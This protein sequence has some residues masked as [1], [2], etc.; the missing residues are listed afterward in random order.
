MVC[1][2]ARRP[3]KLQSV[4]RTLP[5]HKIQQ[6][7]HFPKARPSLLKP[8]V[9]L[10]MAFWPGTPKLVVL[11]QVWIWQGPSLMS[12]RKFKGRLRA[13]AHCTPSL[14]LQANGQIWILQAFLQ[15]IKSLCC[16][17][18]LSTQRK[19]TGGWKT[20]KQ[21]NQKTYKSRA[22]TMTR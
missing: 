15:Y 2:E 6:Q 20:N 16:L 14:L 22:V 12:H 9:P 13:F 5:G 19:V 11:F 18:F 10:H 3:A 8:G 7:P 1:S 4:L 21:T 17:H